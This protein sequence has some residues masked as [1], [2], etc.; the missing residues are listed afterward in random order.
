MYKIYLEIYDKSCR[1]AHVSVDTAKEF[2]LYVVVNFIF[3]R[4]K[5]CY[6]RWNG[7]SEIYQYVSALAIQMNILS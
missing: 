2:A 3:L 6:L 5:G 7:T 4:D 1:R